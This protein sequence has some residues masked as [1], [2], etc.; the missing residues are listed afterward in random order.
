MTYVTEHN[1]ITADS[2]EDSTTDGGGTESAGDNAAAEVGRLWL[3]I[4]GLSDKELEEWEKEGKS[5]HTLLRS[6]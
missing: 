2:V 1:R 4:T 5:L 6:S 3:P